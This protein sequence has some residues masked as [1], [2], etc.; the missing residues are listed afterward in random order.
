M[1]YNDTEYHNWYTKQ[2]YDRI[3][4]FVPKGTRERIKA[5]A[6]CAGVSMNSYIA[7]LLPKS[8]ITERD[9]VRWKEINS[10]ETVCTGN[11]C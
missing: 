3:S 6:R 4:F 1:A 9:F 8:L 2:N 5:A 7:N 10:N 11:E